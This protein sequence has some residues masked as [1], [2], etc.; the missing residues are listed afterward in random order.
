MK[1]IIVLLLFLIIVPVYA[2]QGNAVF[3]D[4]EK[5]SIENIVRD[6]ATVLRAEF[7]L[8]SDIDTL[9]QDVIILNYA[10]YSTPEQYLIYQSDTTVAIQ[11]CL[12][13]V[14][15]RIVYFGGQYTITD[16]IKRD[17]NSGEMDI[18]FAKDAKITSN[19]TAVTTDYYN[20]TGE[21]IFTNGK[22]L[23]I[24]GGTLYGETSTSNGFQS[25]L[26]IRDV[27]QIRLQNLTV[28]RGKYAGVRIVNALNFTADNCH[29][30]S[31]HYA[32]LYVSNTK[33]S[34][35]SGGE[36]SYAGYDVTANPDTGYGITFTGRYVYPPGSSGNFNNENIT[37][38]GVK[39]YYNTRKGIDSHGGQ[40]ITFSDNKVKG[41]GSCGIY[42]VNEDG[43]GNYEKHVRNVIISNN[44]ITQDSTWLEGLLGDR[45][46]Y[47]LT[48]GRTLLDSLYWWSAIQSGDYQGSTTSQMYPPGVFTIQGNVLDSMQ[49]RGSRAPLFIFVATTKLVGYPRY[50]I[51]AI[52]VLNN[53]ILYPNVSTDEFNGDQDAV[54]FFSPGTIPPKF[55]NV[56]GNNI[57][58]DTLQGTANNGIKL[59]FTNPGSWSLVETSDSL[60]NQVV[61]VNNNNIQG[62]FNYPLYISSNNIKQVTSNN[63]YNGK[64][65]ADMSDAYNGIKT[66]DLHAVAAGDSIVLVDSVSVSSSLAPDGGVSYKINI[67]AN[68]DVDKG[69]NEYNFLSYAQDV[70]GTPTFNTIQ[71]SEI[72]WLGGYASTDRPTLTWRTNGSV[73]TLKLF[74]SNGDGYSKYNI[75]MTITS[76]NVP[77]WRTE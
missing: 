23:G 61:N 5:D 43:E 14:G 46:T 9:I 60:Y 6:T 21:I 29:M 53:T 24:S 72:D 44:I 12:D 71:G 35:V 58:R 62:Y 19:F 40:N 49:A 16:S 36:Y 37:V 54:I 57:L 32:N 31:S 30:D 20:P 26:C 17:L 77:Y 59:S 27:N 38:N 45:T 41:F 63:T 15:T 11:R 28:R 68:G 3:K 33:Q 47:Y 64:K 69:I 75:I 74:D 73:G 70:G 50:Q 67:I 42:A 65:L 56:S 25:I 51:E 39:A 1:R 66:I 8:A 52:N 48:Q 13:S 22:R 2:Q 4:T 34:N 10:Q 7:P 76:R 18:V 55:V